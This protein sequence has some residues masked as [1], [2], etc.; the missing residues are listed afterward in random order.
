MLYLS[1]MKQIKI[2]VKLTS[3]TS[4][5]AKKT[6]NYLKPIYLVISVHFEKD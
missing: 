3:F 1:N 6:D 4:K 5:Q 2:Q